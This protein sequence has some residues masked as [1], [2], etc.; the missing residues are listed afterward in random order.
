[1]KDNALKNKSVVFLF[2]IALL[3]LSIAISITIGSV[4][5]ELGE[6]WDIVMG[7]ISFDDP[8]SQILLNIR[9]PRIFMAVF[10]GANLA[11]SGALL[12]GVM[13]NPLADPGVIGVSSGASLAAVMILILFPQLGQYVPLFA[14]GGAM[15]ATF[16]V[17]SMAIQNRQVKPLR[18]VL[19]GV[20]I[21]ALFGGGNSLISVLNSDKIQSVILWLNGSLAGSSWNSLKIISFYSIIGLFLSFFCIRSANLMSLGDEKATNLGLNIALNRILL[22]AVGAFLAGISTAL[23][24]VIGFVGLVIPHICR[25]IIGSDYKWLLPFSMLNGSTFL[26]LADTFARTIASPIELPVGTIMSVIGAPF[27]LYLLRKEGM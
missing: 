5:I 1:M 16:L 3:F 13:Q 12:Q 10:I 19:A 11:T 22:S 25:L 4:R 26:L 2:C 23:V 21:N 6:L 20:A 24:G 17:Y 18:L 15:L 7:R 14:F 27:F 8:K 9:I